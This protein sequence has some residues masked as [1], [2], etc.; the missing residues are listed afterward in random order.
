MNKPV[1]TLAVT[2]LSAVACGATFLFALAGQFAWWKLQQ[3]SSQTCNC[4]C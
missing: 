3:A 2:I 1:V 4:T